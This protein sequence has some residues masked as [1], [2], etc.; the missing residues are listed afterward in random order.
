[1]VGYLRNFLCVILIFP[2][3]SVSTWQAAERAKIHGGAY[4]SAVSLHTL[5]GPKSETAVAGQGN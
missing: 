3:E 2:G 4:V 1:M 5:L